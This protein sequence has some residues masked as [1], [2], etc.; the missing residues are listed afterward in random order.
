MQFSKESLKRNTSERKE[1][2]SFISLVQ[3]LKSEYL[4]NRDRTD[5]EVKFPKKK[6]L[7]VS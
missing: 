4:K 3:I 2:L 7:L 1:I 5:T 6:S